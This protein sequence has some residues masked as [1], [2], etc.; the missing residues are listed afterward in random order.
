MAQQIV[1][2]NE[3]AFASN[4]TAHTQT[5]ERRKSRKISGIG[6]FVFR[7]TTPTVQ[8]LSATVTYQHPPT[9][10]GPILNPT[11]F[12]RTSVH[13]LRNETSRLMGFTVSSSKIYRGTLSYVDTA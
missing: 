13:H 2:Q 7:I 1:K 8:V 3:V 12:A 9:A 11:S 10:P 6:Q 4:G 5:I